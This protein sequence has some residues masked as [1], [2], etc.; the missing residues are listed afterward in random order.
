MASG[1]AYHASKYA[2]EAISDALRFEV[3]GFD[4]KVVIIQPG[5]IRTDFS[6]TAA[7][8]IGAGDG[9]YAA[10]NAG[11]AQSTKEVYEK[12]PLAHFGG[13]PDDVAKAIQKAITA[14]RPKIR[15][16]VTHSAHMLIAQRRMMTDRMWDR[17]LKTQFTPPT[18]DAR[19]VR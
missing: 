8:A 2:V 6:S 5:L 18:L 16:R 11:V 1:G 7:A 10:F 9:P 13:D 17:F 4:V 19:A 14:R 15:M 12:G 3:Q